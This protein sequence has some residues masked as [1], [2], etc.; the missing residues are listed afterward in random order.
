MCEAA[1]SDGDTGMLHREDSSSSW[2]NRATHS[3]IAVK[4]EDFQSFSLRL[5]SGKESVCECVCF[6]DYIPVSIYSHHLWISNVAVLL[7]LDC[8]SSPVCHF[9]LKSSFICTCNEIHTSCLFLCAIL[10]VCDVIG[11]S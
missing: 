2:E 3:K 8:F 6:Y 9:H 4:N 5:V 1:L 10:L 11:G 7:S